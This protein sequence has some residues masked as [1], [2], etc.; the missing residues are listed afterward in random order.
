MR[1][2]EEVF[3]YVMSMNWRYCIVLELSGA[4]GTNHD[5]H[6]LYGLVASMFFLHLFGDFHARIMAYCTKQ[7]FIPV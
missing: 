1:Q 4:G 6:G 3:S 7:F 2:S 5:G